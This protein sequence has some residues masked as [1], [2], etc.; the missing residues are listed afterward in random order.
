M[1]KKKK[2]KNC[3]LLL[4]SHVKMFIK[5]VVILQEGRIYIATQLVL[6]DVGKKTGQKNGPNT[7]QRRKDCHYYIV[8][9][10]LN[11][12]EE[13]TRIRKSRD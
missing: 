2:R 8:F 7:W 1:V 13:R 10:K 5:L 4:H 12:S 11:L 3:V 9:L 6:G